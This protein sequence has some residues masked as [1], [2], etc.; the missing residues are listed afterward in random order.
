LRTA[1]TLDWAIEMP[2]GETMKP[3]NSVVS[4]ENSHFSALAYSQCFQRQER[5]SRTLSLCSSGF[6]EKIS[7]SSKYTTTNLSRTSAKIQ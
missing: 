6:L 2:E 1:S 4:T 7:M 3:R 5:T